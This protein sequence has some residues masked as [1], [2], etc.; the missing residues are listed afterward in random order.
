V[1][2]S[3][4]AVAAAPSFNTAATSVVVVASSI[5][6]AFSSASGTAASATT[7]AS[8]T[9]YYNTWVATS[10]STGHSYLINSKEINNDMRNETKSNGCK[11]KLVRD[12]ITKTIIKKASLKQKPR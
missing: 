11:R 9:S 5:I 7:S 2:S 4:M 10:P 3:S 1:A 12:W 6:A 8:G